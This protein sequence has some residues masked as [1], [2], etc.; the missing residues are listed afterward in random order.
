MVAAVAV[1]PMRE[2]VCAFF[3]VADPGD[4]AVLRRGSLEARLLPFMPQ[5]RFDELLWACAWNFVRGE[6]SMV[7]AQWA[8]RPLVW[9]IYRQEAR[10][11]ELKL[12]AFLDIYLAGLDPATAEALRRFWWAWNQH[13]TPTA[14]SVR[15]AWEVLQPR[16][17]RLAEHAEAWSARLA[18]TGDLAGNLM[19][20]CDKRLK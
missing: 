19:Q 7:R 10:A 12:D 9:H 18:G 17:Q 11:H 4:G 8:A 2:Q 5:A 3:G 20:F 16:W 13:D 1:G 15:A 6:D 14:V